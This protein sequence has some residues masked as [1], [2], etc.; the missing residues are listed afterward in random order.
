MDETQ[1]T[2]EPEVAIDGLQKSLDELLQ[3]ADA[4][5]LSKA[6]GGV[7]VEHSGHYDES[8]KVGGGLAGGGD[9]GGLDDMMIAKMS[10][11]GVPAG[12]IADFA[13]FMTGKQEDDEDEDEEEMEGKY[14]AE[15]AEYSEAN[16][17]Q[18]EPMSKAIDE[19]RAP[20]EDGSTDIADAVDVSPFL[21]TLTMRVAEQIDG[22][23]KSVAE[24][25]G[26]QHNVN[27]HLAAAL[28]QM[29]GLM[30]SQQ[31]VIG[32]LGAR[33][34][35]IERQP[36]Q[37]RG[38][39]SLTGAQAMAKSLPGEAGGNGEQL[40]KSEVLSTLTYM[41]LEKSIK[42]INGRPTY[43]LACLADGGAPM[44]EGTVNAVRTF[45][46]THPHEADAARNYA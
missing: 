13:A 36:A 21:E 19:L 34:G 3:V 2:E 25:H 20:A 29:G 27:A 10:E 40:S 32:E 8:G 11:A 37:P 24:G 1:G 39:T 17:P 31:A 43:E 35:M 41:N 26:T 5:E 44:D 38:A 12:L 18:P 15:Y 30:K 7:S 16:Q 45:L 14:S 33:L 9:I 23:R 4:T 6:Y 28:H 22:I 42:Q 46:R